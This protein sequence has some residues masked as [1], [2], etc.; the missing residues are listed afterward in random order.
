LCLDTD[1]VKSELSQIPETALS[2]DS[3]SPENIYQRGI[4]YFTGTF[5]AQ[6]RQKAFRLFQGAARAGNVKA[7][8]MVADCL[9]SGLGVTEDHEK[10]YTYYLKAAEH[11]FTRAMKTLGF[12]Y[13]EGYGVEPNQEKS[14]FWYAKFKEATRVG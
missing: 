3:A 14:D 7:M 6:D 2:E 4:L 5:V 9:A 10:A 8:Y 1:F 11:G 12:M 13:L